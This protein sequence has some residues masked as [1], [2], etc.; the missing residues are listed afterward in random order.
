[1]YIYIYIYMYLAYL[2]LPLACVLVSTDAQDN[3]RQSAQLLVTESLIP[4]AHKLMSGTAQATL[5]YEMRG[6][7]ISSGLRT[8]RA[9]SR[10][11]PGSTSTTSD[12]PA[13]AFCNALM[14][15]IFL[16]RFGVFT[17]ILLNSCHQHSVRSLIRVFGHYA[18]GCMTLSNVGSLAVQHACCYVAP[19]KSVPISKN[20]KGPAF[21]LQYW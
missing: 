2:L 1:M 6:C 12:S 21:P 18:D 11:S 3:S 16:S 17:L 10:K 15:R 7:G 8:T 13:L 4:N 14:A 5:R 9:S 19:K 20:C